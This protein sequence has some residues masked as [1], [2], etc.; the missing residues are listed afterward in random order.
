MT[1]S[2]LGYDASTNSL[3]AWTYDPSGTADVWKGSLG[4]AVTAGPPAT[5]ALVSGNGQIGNGGR[6]LSAPFIV[7]VTD[8]NG[9]PVSGATVTFAVTGGGG[10]LSAT[11]VTTNVQGQAS[12]T[13][14]LG[15][16]AGVNTVTAS[17]GSLSGSPA[18][19]SATAFSPYDLNLDGVVNNLDVTIAIN[20][21]LGSATCTNGD[22]NGDGA[23]NILDVQLVIA[24]ALGTP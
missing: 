21:A 19:F 23:C 4:A 9:I 2:F 16:N 6:T 15:P 24:A 22:V 10:K 7:M 12:T 20:Q 14:K 17:S 8:A 3:I 13:L 18:T 1:Q 11:T 5:L